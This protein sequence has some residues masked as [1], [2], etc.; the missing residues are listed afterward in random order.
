[1]VAH[2]L[3]MEAMLLIYIA[4]GALLSKLLSVGLKTLK[5]LG[6]MLM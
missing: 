1:M 3:S 5:I 6:Q 4:F 2:Q